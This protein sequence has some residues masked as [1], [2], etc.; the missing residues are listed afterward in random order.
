[1]AQ[2]CQHLEELH[3]L[4][5]SVLVISFGT[6]RG[7]QRWMEET[8][9]PFKLLLDPDRVVYRMYGLERSLRRSWGLKTI[10]RYIRLLA[11]GRRWRGIQGDS[12]QLGG[13]FIIDKNGVIHLAHRSHD[14]TDRPDT[15]LLLNILQELQQANS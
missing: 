10:W 12:A 7:A 13:D 2:L 1:M 6:F 9:T 15:A 14:P 3:A 5:T 11:A 4:D 8:C